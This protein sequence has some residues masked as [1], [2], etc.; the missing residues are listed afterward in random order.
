MI[1]NDWENNDEKED[2]K[3]ITAL[4]SLFLGVNL[5][6]REGYSQTGDR[7]SAAFSFSVFMEVINS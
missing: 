3:I 2:K 7:M 4:A 1:K 5:Q 6:S